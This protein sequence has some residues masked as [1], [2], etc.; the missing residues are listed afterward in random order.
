MIQHPLRA[1]ALAALG[2]VRQGLEGQVVSQGCSR[3]WHEVL[4]TWVGGWGLLKVEPG[5]TA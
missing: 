4:M 3:G 1:V 5:Q 2:E